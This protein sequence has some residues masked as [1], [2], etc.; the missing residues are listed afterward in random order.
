M[1]YNLDLL[2][3]FKINE[4][5]EPSNAGVIF[6][7]LSGLCQRLPHQLTLPLQYF[8]WF[9]LQGYNHHQKPSALDQHTIPMSYYGHAG[10][11]KF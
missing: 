4:C 5:H 1:L 7:V 8:N 11:I 2:F 9:A 6:L 10:T 3:F